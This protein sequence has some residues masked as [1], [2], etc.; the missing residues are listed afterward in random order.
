[1]PSAGRGAGVSGLAVAPLREMRNLAA[2]LDG[3][4][5]KRHV[6]VAAY[7]LTHRSEEHDLIYHATLDL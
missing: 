5:D 4:S 7:L 3:R 2:V 6:G 1:M